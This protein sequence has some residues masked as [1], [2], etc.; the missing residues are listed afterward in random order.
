MPFYFSNYLGKLVG[1]NMSLL[2][3]SHMLFVS[4]LL[5]MSKVEKRETYRKQARDVHMNDIQFRLVHPSV[6]PAEFHKPDRKEVNLY[7][8]LVFVLLP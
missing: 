2:G 8:M 4:L 3:G 1:K 7:V 6:D 5:R